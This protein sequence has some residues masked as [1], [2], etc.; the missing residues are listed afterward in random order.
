MATHPGMI[1]YF[2]IAPKEGLTEMLQGGTVLLFNT[3]DVQ[4]HIMKWAAACAFVNLT[5]PTTVFSEH[6]E[7]SVA[8]VEPLLNLLVTNLYNNARER[9]SLNV[10]LSYTGFI[11]Y[12]LFISN[13]RDTHCELRPHYITTCL[14]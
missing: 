4:E 1:E 6:H 9:F 5:A 10:T 11:G 8:V 7:R 2:P 13:H 3:E 14:G 12:V